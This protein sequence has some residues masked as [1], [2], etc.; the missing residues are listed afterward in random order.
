MYLSRSFNSCWKNTKINVHSIYFWLSSVLEV[1]EAVLRPRLTWLPTWDYAV[2]CRN[3]I[4]CCLQWIERNNAVA[5]NK[6]HRKCGEAWMWGPSTVL[7]CPNRTVVMLLILVLVGTSNLASRKE[8]H[9]LSLMNFHVVCSLLQESPVHC[10]YQE[11]E[12]IV[13]LS[14]NVL[15]KSLCAFFFGFVHQKGVIRDSIF[16]FC[17]FWISMEWLL[18]E[19]DKTP[20]STVHNYRMV[21]AGRNLWLCL[22]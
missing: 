10:W 20:L 9:M 6:N 19:K 12:T 7:N 22:F 8:T 2:L 17:F 11:E 4:H 5:I 21:E 1:S 16:G 3:T 15:R 14:E 18:S 13:G